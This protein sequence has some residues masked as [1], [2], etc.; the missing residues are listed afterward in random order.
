MDSSMD[1]EPSKQT[2]SLKTFWWTTI[3]IAAG[4]GLLVAWSIANTSSNFW[5]MEGI[6]ASS[7]REQIAGLLTIALNYPFG[8]LGY[9]FFETKTMVLIFIAANSLLW[10]VLVASIIFTFRS[11]S[12]W[13]TGD[14]K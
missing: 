11:L 5:M 8:L 9:R 3:T 13:A 14:R 6:P 1:V 12:R 4:H 7:S 10:G 2:E